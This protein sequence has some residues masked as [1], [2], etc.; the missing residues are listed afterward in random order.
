MDWGIKVASLSTARHAKRKFGAVLTVEDPSLRN[1]LRFHATPHPD[2]LV[3]RFED[4]DEWTE[5]VA[6][7]D[8]AHV[9]AALDFGR[10]H[11]SGTLLVHCKAGVARSTALALAII[12]DRMGPGMEREAVAALL[13]GRPQAIPNLLVLEFADAALGRRGALQ[14][15]WME[16]E[17]SQRG[18]SDHRD[19]KRTVLNRNPSL[20]SKP[21]PLELTALRFRPNALAGT[22]VLKG[23]PGPVSEPRNPA[24]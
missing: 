2:Q 24:V 16:V 17:R 7:A 8:P 21:I 9:E 19:L 10:D 3:L 13:S 5:G 6:V 14:E 11:R 18:Y 15:A 4:V 12:A 23:L 1:G 20:Y 22:Q